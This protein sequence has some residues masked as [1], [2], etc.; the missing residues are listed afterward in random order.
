MAG[1]AAEIVSVRVA[2]PAP[3]LLVALRVTLEVAAVVGVPEINPVEV[4]TD[5]PAG[6]LAAPKLVGKLVAVI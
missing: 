4:L 3:E 1:A 2:L 5:R 6:K